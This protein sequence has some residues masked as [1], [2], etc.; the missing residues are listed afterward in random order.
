MAEK[1]GE[2]KI[3]LSDEDGPNDILNEPSSV[4]LYD[5]ELSGDD[6]SDGLVNEDLAD[7]LPK[8]EE[9]DSGP[10]DEE[11]DLGMDEIG[12]LIEDLRLDVHDEDETVA[13][14][15]GEEDMVFEEE[16]A[17]DENN[18]SVESLL[19]E[20]GGDESK[21]D[22]G[23]DASSEVE[24]NREGEVASESESI[25]DE[26]SSGVST[27]TENLELPDDLDL[28][29]D[30]GEMTE[31]S[32]GAE[33]LE[34][35]TVEGSAPENG[36]PES[37]EEVASTPS[38][39]EDS[40]ENETVEESA[41]EDGEIDSV[42]EVI[43][44]EKTDESSAP[45]KENSESSDVMEMLHD[46]EITEKSEGEDTEEMELGMDA[47]DDV[48]E[49]E[50]TVL[51][52]EDNEIELDDSEEP[53]T[54]DSNEETATEW[55][56]DAET[57]A[58]TMN[59]LKEMGE[60]MDSLES[61]EVEFAVLDEKLDQ[62]SSKVDEVLELERD[63]ERAQATSDISGQLN[64]DTGSSDS[65]NIISKIIHKAGE[66]LHTE[67]SSNENTEIAIPY[68]ETTVAEISEAPLGS[69]MLLNFTHEVVVEMARTRLTGEEI[70][71]ITYGSIIEL[72]KVAGEPVNL[73]L[74]GKTIAFGEVVQIN[75]EKL[76]IR[77]VGV[78]QE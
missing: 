31:L 20:L 25:D 34:N 54:G 39:E 44:T 42:K 59:E 8:V 18:D 68:E 52:Q 41:P 7:T 16:E 58:D 35:E 30:L 45:A 67:I 61:T 51:D 36:G 13:S 28:S 24:I 77:I 19:D 69:D 15:E 6:S 55:F 12:N 76:G 17:E 70:T 65:S 26:E 57:K 9:T 53:E 72:D 75:N 40:V 5:N 48:E 29:G 73:V 33:S 63:E 4:D 47:L 50:L 2:H 62:I 46:P 56:A 22:I 60:K 21:E 32:D 66:V 1:P 11:I 71:Q 14:G 64:A 3:E 78:V 38:D 43:S 23:S 49:T 74:D 27:E 10:D 37:T